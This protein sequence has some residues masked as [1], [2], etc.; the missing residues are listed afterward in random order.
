MRKT[1]GIKVD[2][3][4]FRGMREGVP[5]LIALFD[6]YGIKASF[7]VPM[8]KDHTGR[9]VKRVLRRGFL[10][11]AGRV[12]V[13]DT[14]GVRTLLYGL[15]LPGPEIAV[16]NRSLLVRIKEDGHEVGIHGLDHVFWHDNIRNLSR[17]RTIEELD[18]AVTVYRDVFREEPRAFAAPGWNISTFAL[19]HLKKSGFFYTS[20]ARGRFPFYPKL[21]GRV[22]PL[23]EIPSTLPTL[24]EMVGMK[25]TDPEELARYFL[26]LLGNGLEILTVHTELEGRKWGLFLENLVRGAL[27][28]GY[29]FSRL[30]DIAEML[31]K[32]ATPPPVA[33]VMFGEIEGRAGQV[34]L[35]A[36]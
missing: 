9:T 36:G 28:K 10:E 8:G 34:C 5:S 12:G 31:E 33:K 17:E 11:K 2:V 13:V 1:I 24:D 21:E 6:R 29:T 19:E 35:Q 25:G 22:F 7:F 4:T 23:L 26:S 30:A 14:Y 16:K 27:D 32:D 3:D 18:R 20:N 15:L